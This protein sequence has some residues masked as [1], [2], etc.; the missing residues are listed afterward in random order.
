MK[1]FILVGLMVLMAGIAKA[2]SFSI[3]DQLQKIPALKQGIAFS[4]VDNKV[5]YL[6]TLDLVQWK[7]FS[8]EAG[9]AGDAEKTNHKAVAVI[10]YD[11]L[12]LKKLG[13]T[14]PVLDLIDV[15][16]GGYI[17]YGRIN[18]GDQT[19]MDGNNELDYGLSAT[20]LS[21]KF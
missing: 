1:K 14:V 5:N 8:L 19:N 2:E 10:S 16:L 11:V 15:R 7:G 9:Y 21:I 20:A 6:S 12:N 3:L 4:L 13:V 17:G 18:I